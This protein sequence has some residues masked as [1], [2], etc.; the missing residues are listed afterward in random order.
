M[1]KNGRRLS[2]LVWLVV[3]MLAFHSYGQKKVPSSFCLHPVEKQL[4][5][6][7]NRIRVSHGKKV[8]P[9]SVS[10]AYVARVHVTDLLKNHPDTSICN[11]SSWSNKGAWKPCCY[12]RY[13][14]N[15]DCM[16]KKPK[17]LTT[18]PY[19][20]YE[21]AAY[22]QDRLNID[23]ILSMWEVS[24]EALDMILTRGIWEKKT[25][26]CFGVAVNEHYV[27]V[28]F[29]QRPD[30]AGKPKMCRRAGSSEAKAKATSHG[31]YLVYGSYPDVTSASRA[32]KQLKSKGFRQ[33]GILK[34][35]RYVRVYL[36][37]ATDFQQ[38]KKK[39]QQWLKKYPGLWI[40]QN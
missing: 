15:H 18:Y 4:A 28:W 3:M 10:L 8:L 31:Y 24:P 6:S 13:V 16:W 19:R 1:M 11:L 21:M 35:H 9:L 29:G 7:I 14:V 23:S 32:L 40:L 34:S 5:D 33:A 20:G 12:N 39:R 25:W 22:S 27:S 2:V 36:F 17:E 26:A 30:R 38:M 37:H